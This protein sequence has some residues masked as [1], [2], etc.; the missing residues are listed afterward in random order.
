MPDYKALGVVFRKAVMEDCE[1]SA[2]IADLCAWG[3]ADSEVAEL[4]MWDELPSLDLSA[5]YAAIEHW[6]TEALDVFANE[7]DLDIVEI[8][9]A[10]EPEAF[11]IAGMPCVGGQAAINGF[12]AKHAKHEGWSDDIDW[13]AETELV[14]HVTR[15]LP[16]QFWKD[17]HDMV[18]EGEEDD[19]WTI[20]AAWALWGTFC[21]HAVA[22]TLRSEKIDLAAT[23]G[24]RKQVPVLIGSGDE[25]G[26]MG[27]LT[28]EGWKPDC[29]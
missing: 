15:E 26:Y 8:R 11:G 16:G 29:H 28:P 19:R 18:D 4:T 14:Y 10:D 13:D 24:E 5:D 3:K 7:P 20:D 21:R 17:M 25:E 6:V 23:L 9:L 12:V 1:P 2:L 27:L 22:R